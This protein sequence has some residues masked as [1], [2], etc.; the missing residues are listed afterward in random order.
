METVIFMIKE[1]DVLRVNVKPKA[2]NYLTERLTYTFSDQTDSSAVVSLVW[3]KLS[4][5]FTVSTELQKSATG[6]H[7]KRNEQH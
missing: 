3:E 2:Q 7:S 4:I 1:D 6:K 5:P